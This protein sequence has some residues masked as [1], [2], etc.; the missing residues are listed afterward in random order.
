[1]DDLRG[2]A[3][4]RGGGGEV[5]AIASRLWSTAR[6]VL[7]K[8]LVNLTSPHGK[9]WHLSDGLGTAAGEHYSREG[10]GNSTEDI[11]R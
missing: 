10:V 9:L 8:S 11:L 7:H 6:I 4:R 2:G 1:M 5:I 3:V